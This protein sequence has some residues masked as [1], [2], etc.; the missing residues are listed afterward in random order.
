[1]GLKKI[2]MGGVVLSLLVSGGYY[3]FRFYVSDQN[4]RQ[5]YEEVYQRALIKHDLNGDG[6]ISLREKKE[7]DENI[8][9]MI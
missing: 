3:S 1:M 4:L 9:F 2:V 8:P 6:Y 5:R 7:L